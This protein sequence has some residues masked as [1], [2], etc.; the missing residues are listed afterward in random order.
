MSFLMHPA[1]LSHVT[2]TAVQNWK[3]QAR[4]ATPNR[5]V[6]CTCKMA[7]TSVAAKF[8]AYQAKTKELTDQ[9]EMK[10]IEKMT[11]E[12]YCIPIPWPFQTRGGQAGS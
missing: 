4:H 3:A 12:E 9:E 1:R 11:L 6:I 2:P 8:K 5:R 10:L 7:K